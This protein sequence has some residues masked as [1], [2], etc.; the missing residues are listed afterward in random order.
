VAEDD[1]RGA[2]GAL[3]LGATKAAVA[4]T[5]SPAG[6]IGLMVGPGF[7]PLLSPLPLISPLPSPAVP[8]FLPTQFWWGG[9]M[10]IWICL[11]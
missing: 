9:Q 7:P 8:P 11:S 3:A 6:L 1:L 4:H 5:E 2:Q 10:E